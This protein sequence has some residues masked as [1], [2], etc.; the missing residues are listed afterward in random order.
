MND[1]LLVYRTDEATMNAMHQRTP[2]EMKAN[3]RRWMDWVESLSAQQKL[4]DIGNRLMPSG[5]VVKS[6]QVI[7][8]G[9]F[10][11]IKECIVGYTIIKATSFEEAAELAKGCPILAM[12]G[13]VEV[14][15]IDAIEM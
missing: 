3:A 13:N 5:K 15:K 2:D 10:I 12:G 9:P 1:F 4:T 7:A 14:R 8:D 11:E 6:D